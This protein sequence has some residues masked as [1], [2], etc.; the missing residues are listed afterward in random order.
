MVIGESLRAARKKAR[1]IQSELAERIG[2]HEV[3]LRSWE[4]NAY[5]PRASDIRKLCEVLGVSEDELLN[6]PRKEEIEIRVIIEETNEWEVGTMDLRENSKD[7]FSVH[8]G[9]E[10]IGVEFTG[11][12]EKPEDLDDVFARARKCAEETLAAQGRL[13]G[14]AEG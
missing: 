14:A 10:K 8:I 13:S 12:F 3:T 11:K 7:R 1:L 6:G 9:P 4:R 2:V 5:Q